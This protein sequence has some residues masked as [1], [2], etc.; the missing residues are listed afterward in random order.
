MFY[1]NNLEYLELNVTSIDNLYRSNNLISLFRFKQN[2][3]QLDY[4]YNT[5]YKDNVNIL[6]QHFKKQIGL[7]CC[8]LVLFKS[9]DY[10]KLIFLTFLIY[11]C[12]L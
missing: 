5:R 12:Y 3:T 1:S 10:V 2:I 7:K 8:I 9:V 4:S 11:I 6:V